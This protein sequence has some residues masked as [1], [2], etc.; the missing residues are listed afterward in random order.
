MDLILDVAIDF[1][2]IK[3]IFALLIGVAVGIIGGG[4]PGISPSMTIALLLPVSLYL[5]ATVAIA[6]MIGSYQGAM[7]GGSISAILINTPGTA[8]AAATTLDGYQMAA[9]GQSGKALHMALFAS[10]TG[11]LVGVI[12]LLAMAKPLSAVTLKF[13][14]PEYFGLM[15]LSLSLIAG[16]SGK[17][18]IRGIISAG[19]GLLIATV[20]MDPIY[21]TKRFTFGNINLGDG[22]Q[23]LS[24]FIGV[25]ALAELLTQLSKGKSELYAKAETLT[26]KDNTLSV[27]EYFSNFKTMIK[28][29]VMGALIG[30]LPGIGGSTACFISY[31]EAQRVSKHPEKFGTGIL[32][33]IA[34]PEAANNAVS[35]GALVPMLTL[36]IPGDVVTAIL[37]GALIAH[38]IKPGPLLFVENIESVYTIYI[39]LLLSVIGLLIVGKLGVPIFSKIVNIR[40]AT[41]LPM[42]LIICIVGTY[43]TR[44]N[45]FDPTIMIVFGALGF[46]MKINKFPIPPLV[47]AF[48]IGSQLESSLRQSLV[49]S[50]GSFGI[51]FTRPISAVLIIIAVISAVF[52]FIRNKRFQTKAEMS[53]K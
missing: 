35:G 48:V 17:S 10:C 52:M 21:G 38:G 2:S 15:V 25:F 27:K 1:I 23:T 29:G 31:A 8:S 34:A 41:L 9:N 4:M 12:I 26:L 20:G 28:S 7:F 14:P 44:T 39:A 40:K 43:S 46:I 11:G 24:V 13:G 51:F 22:V 37:V 18:L 19:L 49:L 45:L 50:D 53:E 36:G 42:I 32:E 16:I 3:V 30:V 47:I 5:P 6:L 33:G